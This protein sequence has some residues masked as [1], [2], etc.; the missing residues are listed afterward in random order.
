MVSKPDCV[1]FLAAG[2][3]LLY[4]GSGTKQCVVF[5]NDTGSGANEVEAEWATV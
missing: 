1:I 2:L 3:E 5:V 4:R